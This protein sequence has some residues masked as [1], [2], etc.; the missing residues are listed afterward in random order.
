MT[1]A[2]Q[3]SGG[4]GTR[5]KKD[6]AAAALAMR[7]TRGIA[8]GILLVVL[9]IWAGLV[10][11]IGPYFEYQADQTGVWAF[12]WERFWLGILPAIVAIV[13]GALLGPAANKAVGSLGAWLG[14][15]AGIWLVIGPSV[16]GYWTPLSPSSMN[17]SIVEQ[18]GLFYGL[19]A[20]ITAVAAFA[21]GRM[22]V[23]SV[24]DVKD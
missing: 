14:V 7:R 9:G 17:M 11:F 2:E 5:S 8:S 6:E 1:T 10:Q 19:G 3:P 23:R 4:A 21:L 20:V 13:G 15:V 12:T 24:K 18:I 16:A 22:T